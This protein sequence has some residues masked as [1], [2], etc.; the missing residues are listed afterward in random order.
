MGK[1]YE[2]FHFFLQLGNCQL[3]DLIN[4]IVGGT[5]LCQSRQWVTRLYSGAFE[6]YCSN[7][8]STKIEYPDTKSLKKD[9]KLIIQKGGESK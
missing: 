3:P 2:S 5:R 7:V 1:G 6:Q 9:V 8:T 4:R